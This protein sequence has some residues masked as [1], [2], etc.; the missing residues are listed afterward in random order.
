MKS[1]E[2]YIKARADL[3]K[4]LRELNKEDPYTCSCDS[5]LIWSALNTECKRCEKP[6]A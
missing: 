6:L 4:K 1:Q 2:H 5:P 3:K